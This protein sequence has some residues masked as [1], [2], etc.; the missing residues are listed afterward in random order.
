MKLNAFIAIALGVA[1]VCAAA[2]ISGCSAGG[3]TPTPTPTPVK[4]TTDVLEKFDSLKE[5]VNASGL[6]FGGAAT[7]LIKGDE[8]AMV[9]VYK[10]AGSSD[11]TDLLA[12]GYSALYSVFEIKDP[13]LVGLIDTTQ[14]IND[15]QYKV[16][17]YAMERPIVE[18]YAEGDITQS[19]LVNKAIFVTPE[20]ESLRAADATAKPTAMLPTPT[21]NY[22][23]PADRQAYVVESLNRTGY[24]GSL[25]A[26]TLTDGS[27]AVN[28]LLAMPP[29]LSNAQK[30]AELDAA[31]K[32]CAEAFGDYDRF[33]VSMVSE[34]GNEYYVVDAGAV[35]VIDYV[36][37][38][39]SQYD[40]YNNINLTYYTK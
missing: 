26:G 1:I 30:Y 17:V 14:K 9:Y 6:W 19:E 38:D 8:T 5:K 36:N 33:Y 2:A 34:S 4:T 10:P 27:N 24:T 37:G 12:G 21:R 29:G 23:P 7:Q 39:I 16:D 32:A 11:V 40:L 25:Q 28:L 15:Q 3:S 13:L 35:P 31:F 18:L 22:T 20:T